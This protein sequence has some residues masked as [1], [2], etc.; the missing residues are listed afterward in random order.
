M[1]PQSEAEAFYEENTWCL[2]DSNLIDFGLDEI[3][4]N[5]Y[6]KLVCNLEWENGIPFSR[7]IMKK[8][9]GGR[10]V[11]FRDPSKYS[12]MDYEIKMNNV[13][14]ISTAIPDG[15]Q[16]MPPIFKPLN[17]DKF[18]I[19]IDPFSS[20]QVTHGNGS[21]A[22]MFG[23]WKHDIHIDH[24][25]TP[26]EQMIT[27]N[28]IFEYICRPASTLILA[29]DVIK[30]CFFLGCEVLVETN[31]TTLLDQFDVWGMQAFLMY[32][33][34]FNRASQ[35]ALRMA[36]SPGQP[37]TSLSKEAIVDALEIYLTDNYMRC[38]SQKLL[39]DML[40]FDIAKTEDYDACM[41]AGY[42]LIAAKK[43]NR[44]RPIIVN[45]DVNL[46]RTY[47]KSGANSFRQPQYSSEID[48]WTPIS[49]Q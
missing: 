47:K 42:T 31:K 26:R 12:R 29:Q 40:K 46:Y 14:R 3:E 5:P 24:P 8:T 23:Y 11:F 25:G 15:I 10:F 9:E 6:S 44:G 35:S 27:D 48:N 38:P 37:S 17:T 32:Q 16:E 30:A 49:K 41:G 20:K 18:A 7:V 2:F 34:I 39:L 13:Q 36:E 1:Y 28:F 43:P 22:G 4:R 45:Q 33:Q 21:N 19:A